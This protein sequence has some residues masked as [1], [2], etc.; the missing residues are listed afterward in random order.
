MKKK[1]IVFGMGIGI[2]ILSLMLFSCPMESE[3]ESESDSDPAYAKEYWGEWLRMDT[4]ATWYISSDDIIINNSS[5]PGSVS[6]SKQSDRVI[7][8]KDGSRKYYLYASRTASTGFTGK[9]ASFGSSASTRAVGGAVG[10]IQVAVT[11][12]N[13]K[14]N[15]SNAT[16]DREGNFRV[17]EVIPGDEYEL[18][19][20]GQRTTVSPTADGDDVGTITVTDGV[21]FKTSIKPESSVDMQRL[22]ASSSS[23]YTF[24]ITVENT[25]TADCTAAIFRLDFDDDLTVSSEPPDKVLGTIEPGKRK[26]IRVALTCRPVQAEYEFKKIGVSITD[27]INN[28]TWNDSVSL[29]FNKT[30]VTF[31]IRAERSISGVVIT[32]TA[33]AYPFSGT[34]SSFT[35]PWSSRDYLVV[36]S[37][38][39][40]DTE[41]KYSVGINVAADSVFSAFTD[42]GNYEN[43][44]TETTAK[45]INVS[46]KIVS[47]LHKNDIDYYKIKLGSTA[48]TAPAAPA[49][50]SATRQSPTSIS[51]SWSPV[52]D[53]SG[54]YVYR[55]TSSS[56]TF[57]RIREITGSA[58]TSYTDSGLSSS[59]TYYYIVYAYNNYGV[60]PRSDYAT[61]SV[62]STGISSITYGSVSGGAWTLQGDEWRKSPVIGHGSVTKARIYFTTSTSNA[63]IAIQLEVSSELNYDF[64]FISQL[65]NA[66]ATYTSGYYSG[67]VIS[68]TNSVTI[69]IPVSSAGS[70]F[71]DIGYRKDGSVD[72][73]SDCAWFKV[74][75]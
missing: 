34:S 50:I 18:T 52:S 62:S 6:L 19:V 11:N 28:R 57:T 75:P 16:T 71:I 51:I 58:S 47:Y 20:G 46:D 25:G 23:P 10:N 73:G 41:T 54:Y 8:V 33:K 31:N 74:A 2:G 48:P 39:T 17:E 7:E 64:A 45:A 66:S 56:T 24:I 3:S 12:L 36:F 60:S 21:N 70:H 22:Y 26:T 1:H 32:P 30:P 35:M 72:S 65:D 5:S 68:G 67:S 4:G 59:T 53:A 63:S 15:K 9:I 29:K 43:N 61:P 14:A 42:V 55:A 13:N 44:N 38:A 27:S 49:S 69:I 40:A 37:G